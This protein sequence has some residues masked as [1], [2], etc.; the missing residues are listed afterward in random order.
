LRITAR[1]A[2]SA[3]SAEVV[4]LGAVELGIEMATPVSFAMGG[5]EQEVV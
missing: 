1:T 4:E 5:A 3:A 2:S